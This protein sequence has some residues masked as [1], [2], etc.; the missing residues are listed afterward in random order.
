[1]QTSQNGRLNRYWSS[2]LLDALLI[3]FVFSGPVINSLLFIL[4]R[5]SASGQMALAYIVVAL[6]SFAL[7]LLYGSRYL[8]D[9]LLPIVFLMAAATAAFLVTQYRYGSDNASFLSEKRAFLGMEVCCLLLAADIVWMDAADIDLRLIFVFDVVLSV[10]SFLALIRGDGLTTGGL[11]MDSSGFLYQNIAYYCAYCFGMNVFLLAETK[12]LDGLPLRMPLFFLLSAL[13]FFTCFMS[14]GRGGAVLMLGFLFYG[15]WAIY[16]FRN[17]YKVVLPA[18]LALAA[19]LFVF[20]YAVGRSGLSSRGLMRVLS[21]F[22]GG[23]GN[24]L[25]DIGRATRFENALEIFLEKPLFGHGIGS[26]FYFMGS[27]SHNMFMDI[28]AE[29]GVIGLM[30][31]FLILA[32]AVRRGFRLYREGSLYRFLVVLLIGG[33]TLNLFSG[34][35]WVNQHIWLPVT[36]FLLAPDPEPAAERTE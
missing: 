9:R 2:V 18:A 10:I 1:M 5:R 3:L 32:A 27:Y 12:D 30:T 24:S 13:Q 29:T 20:P 16:G 6:G 33:L 19:V 15:I 17:V 36:V 14:G 26:I 23:A 8:P 35:F 31:S 7:A 11:V 21:L 28:L 25:Y 34:Y 4:N 22:G